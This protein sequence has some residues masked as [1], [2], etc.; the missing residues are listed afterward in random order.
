[1]N[2][3]SFELILKQGFQ[4]ISV[5]SSLPLHYWSLIELI[6]RQRNQPYLK[7]SKNTL[8]LILVVEIDFLTCIMSL[9]LLLT[10]AD[11][12]S[13]S[14]FLTFSMIFT[15]FQNRWPNLSE[16]QPLDLVLLPFPLSLFDDAQYLCFPYSLI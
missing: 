6:F 1:M 8:P 13:P 16:R 4:L 9:L 2:Y 10:E 5:R 14:S 11:R 15:C 12:L 7:E 3:Q